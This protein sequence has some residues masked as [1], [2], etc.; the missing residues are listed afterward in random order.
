M[1]AAA[2]SS[3]RKVIRKLTSTLANLMRTFTHQPID[4]ESLMSLSSASRLDAIRT[5]SDLS[6]RVGS[7]YSLRST[8]SHGSKKSRGRS[9]TKR[10][11]DKGSRH[12]SS[13]HRSRSSKGGRVSP[14]P[15][16]NAH[17]FQSKRV[18]MATISS[19]STKLGEIRGSRVQNSLPHKVTYPLHTY[20]SQAMYD[21][22]NTRS[23]KRWFGL[24]GGK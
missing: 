13:K 10:S 9:H 20:H 8:R 19:G 4:H 11:H 15:N 23:K 2:R 14:E 22:A 21:E 1:I 6:G 24:F 12:E 5:M 3:L 16:K 7:T 17:D 18:S